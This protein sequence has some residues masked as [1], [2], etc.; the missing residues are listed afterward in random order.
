ML[1]F[2]MVVRMSNCY[3]L[4]MCD[5][6]WKKKPGYVGGCGGVFIG[7]IILPV[8]PKEGDLSPMQPTQ[9]RG[10]GLGGVRPESSH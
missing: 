9:R 10:P 1:L 6:K 5:K 2:E 8:S 3:R 4:F 7:A